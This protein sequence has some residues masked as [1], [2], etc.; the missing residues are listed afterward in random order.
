M[1]IIGESLAYRAA[2]PTAIPGDLYMDS[3]YGKSFDLCVP[4]I[5]VGYR[6]YW[7][8]RDAPVYFIL[9]IEAVI[10]YAVSDQGGSYPSN[11]L[12]TM[13]PILGLAW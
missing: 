5:E 9:G 7:P 4:Y 8:E 10:G 12:W 6:Y 11:F 2:H 3:K 13:T 1:K